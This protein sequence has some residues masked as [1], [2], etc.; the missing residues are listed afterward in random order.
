MSE[1]THNYSINSGKT[2][3]VRICEICNKPSWDPRNDA[4]KGHLRDDEVPGLLR[5][6][7]ERLREENKTIAV[8]L[9]HQDAFLAGM[10]HMKD[11]QNPDFETWWCKKM[12]GREITEAEEIEMQEEK[13]LDSYISEEAHKAIIDRFS[14]LIRAE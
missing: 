3:N 2:I 9:G 13:R 14:R 1:D 5:D 8:K 7:T 12:E 10:K 11:N 6:V 4:C